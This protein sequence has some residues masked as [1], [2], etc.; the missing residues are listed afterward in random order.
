MSKPLTVLKCGRNLKNLENTISCR[1]STKPHARAKAFLQSKEKK[2]A[3]KHELIQQSFW[4]PELTPE[5]AAKP[6]SKPSKLLVCPEYGHKITLKSLQDLKIEVDA[7]NYKFLCSGCLTP[8][9]F[10]PASLLSCG[11]LFCTECISPTDF[12]CLKC[13][14]QYN[15]KKVIQLTRGGTMFAAHNNVEA[16]VVKP[17]FQC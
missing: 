12:V 7:A 3:S 2:I 9:T 10:Q 15:P 5:N 1:K 16:T 13:G 4:V 14:C 6:E 8:F 17:V 11:H